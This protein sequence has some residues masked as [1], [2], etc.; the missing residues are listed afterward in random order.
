MQLDTACEQS[1]RKPRE[2]HAM[3]DG[4]L[5][6]TSFDHFKLGPWPASDA[7]ALLDQASVASVPGIPSSSAAA[8]LDVPA[9][10]VSPAAAGMQV[11][12]FTDAQQQVSRQLTMLSLRSHSLE[13]ARSSPC[14]SSASLAHPSRC[15]STAEEV[16]G[17][18]ADRRKSF[19]PLSRGPD[20]VL[21]LV[22]NAETGVPSITCDTLVQLQTGQHMFPITSVCMIDCR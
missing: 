19:S 14:S 3:P 1:Q 11:D 21:P 5:S 22:L 20:S 17:Q 4:A 7:R 16:E 18:E 9:A 8:M 2:V 6:Q 13:K 10:A 15:N 12:P